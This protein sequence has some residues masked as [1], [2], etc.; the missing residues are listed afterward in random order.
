MVFTLQL[1][2]G[3]VV[4]MTPASDPEMNQPGFLDIELVL[5]AKKVGKSPSMNSSES[6]SIAWA[7]FDGLFLDQH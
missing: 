1:A 2:D 7:A 5:R 3:S 6:G 4:K